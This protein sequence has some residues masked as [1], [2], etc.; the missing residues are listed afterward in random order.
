MTP[1]K[2]SPPAAEEL[3]DRTCRACQS[4]YRY[5]VPHSLAT[6]FYCDA[7]MELP[8]EVRGTIE[9]LTKQLKQLAGRI[10]KLE[11]QQAPGE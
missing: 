3:Q 11:R 1:A 7:C 8:A 6:R 9:K 10:D 4:P 2:P 5:P